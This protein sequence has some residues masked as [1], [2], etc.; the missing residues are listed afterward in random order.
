M[1]LGEGI[2]MEGKECVKR[3]G[4]YTKKGRMWRRGLVVLMK[5]RY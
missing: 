1:I 3:K 2:V 4:V 5:G